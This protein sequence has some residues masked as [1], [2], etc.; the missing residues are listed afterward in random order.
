MIVVVD[1][2]MGNLHSVAKALEEAGGRTAVTSDPA[3]VAKASKLVL[4]GVE[5]FKDA[6]DALARDG[7]IDPILEHVRAGRKFLG[8]CLG[9]QLL[10]DLGHEDGTHRG[11]GVIRGEVVQVDH[12][13]N[14]ITNVP[15]A[16]LPAGPLRVTVRGRDLP[17][18]APTY[19]AIPAGRLAALLGSS[20]R[21]EIA[22]PNRSAAQMLR[23]FPGDS[24]EVKP[25][26]D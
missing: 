23:A 8:I 10:F 11:L 3:V 18:L 20:G 15:A 26:G 13:G 9:L 24:V 6:R 22:S 21:L 5:A 2:G 4:P 25:E 16:L 14:L 7:L 17:G 19:A 1:Y 12:F